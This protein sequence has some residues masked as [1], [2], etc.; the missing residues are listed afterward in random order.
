M[1]APKRNAK[2]TPLVPDGL[3][4]F[5]YSDVCFRCDQQMDVVGHEGIGVNLAVPIGRRFLQPVE[6][7]VIVLLS[8]ETRL[9]VDPALNNVLR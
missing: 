2:L 4:E 3:N 5:G 7:N 6:V 9:S 8:K 1:A